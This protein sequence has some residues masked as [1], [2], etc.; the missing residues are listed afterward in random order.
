M[1]EIEL[2]LMLLRYNMLS[3]KDDMFADMCIHANT[4]AGHEHEWAE[5]ID[6]MTEIKNELRKHGYELA[7][8]D[9]KTEGKLCY[10]VYKLVPI[11][12]NNPPAL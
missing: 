11:D 3:K 9:Y 1:S 12:K 8:D 4:I 6:E 5:C 7:Y 2:K 10:S